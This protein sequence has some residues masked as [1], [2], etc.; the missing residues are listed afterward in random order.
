MTVF[1]TVVLYT[2]TD[3]FAKFREEDLPLPGGTPK[4]L[5]SDLIPSSGFQVRQSPPGVSS[6]FHC[7]TTA[8]WL[9]VLSGEME[10][11]LRDGTS[12]IFKAGE[13]FFSNDTLPDGA[14]FD[15]HVHG[16]RSRVLG[17]SPLTTL[18]VRTA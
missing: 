9:V 14:T 10:I 15:P 5:L 13:H 7:T 6:D 4:A 8:Q 18:F 12:R 1:K 3:G 16:H 2:D 11:G 17:N